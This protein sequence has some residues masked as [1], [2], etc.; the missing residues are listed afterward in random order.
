MLKWEKGGDSPFIHGLLVHPPY[1]AISAD[2][3][4][5]AEVMKYDE[6]SIPPLPGEGDPAG[7]RA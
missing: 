7:E 4:A 3:D 1:R 5:D 6:R 2:G